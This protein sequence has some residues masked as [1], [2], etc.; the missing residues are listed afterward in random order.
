[1]LTR[2]GRITPQSHLAKLAL[3]LLLALAATAS[4]ASGTGKG[5]RKDT[6]PP[7]VS[8]AAPNGG[9]T[10]TGTFSVSGTASDNVQVANV[11]VSVDGGPYR[12]ATGTT[13]WSV[14]LN[15]SGY[16]DG[17]HTLTAKATDTSGKTATTVESV[18][19]TNT[20]P[21]PTSAPPPPPPPADTTAP[22]VAFS[23][24][25]AAS[26]INGSVSVTGTAA[27]DTGLAKVELRVDSGAYQPVQGTGSWSAPLTTAA[28]ADGTHI[29][30]A[31]A[32]DTAGN[33][34]TTSESV[35]FA[36]PSSLPSG[37]ADQLVTP[38]GATI[39]VYSDVSGWTAQQVYDLLKKNA[40]QLAL[41]GPSLTVKMQTTYASAT[42]TSAVKT[43][44]V[45]GSYKATMYLQAKSGTAF[46]SNPDAILA[47][48]YGHAWT[49]YHLYLSHNGDWTP[50]LSVRGILGDPRLDSS[51]GWSKNEMIA[52]DYRLLFGTGAAQDELAYLNPDV[53]DP[54]TVAG[55]KDFFVNVWGS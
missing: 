18:T 31:S 26:T 21:P 23:T 29:L 1:M 43:N 5:G 15:S 6:T 12:S 27:D 17:S 20:P 4:A 19:F 37:V 30:T 28:Y 54:R 32:T 39:Q 8:I 50:Y 38:E 35:T 24:P 41:V 14:S 46:T 55:L 52:D 16:A 13:S 11:Q 36:N 2:L 40:Y 47:H 9:T 48:E 51:Y 3:A 22:T 44:G 53:S 49:L 10:V 7:S 42:S 33:V 45:Y 34:T 25:A